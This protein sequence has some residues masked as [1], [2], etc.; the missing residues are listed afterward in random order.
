MVEGRESRQGGAGVPQNRSKYSVGRQL[1]RQFIR[2]ILEQMGLFIVVSMVVLYL[3]YDW[4]QK[5]VWTSITPF[6]LLIHYVHQHLVPCVIIWFLLGFVLLLGYRLLRMIWCMD[7]VLGSVNDLYMDNDHM[8]AMP[9]ELQSVEGQLQRIKFDAR[10]SREQAREAEQRKNDLIVYMAHDL[11]TPLTSVI[12][13]LSLL[14]EEKEISPE[15]RNKYQQIALRKAERLEELINEFFE[16]TRFNLSKMTLELSEINMTTM[17]EQIR[18]EFQ[19]LFSEKKLTCSLN[20]ERNLMVTCDVDKM[21]RVFDN[22]LKN[23]VNYSYENTE[24][25]IQAKRREDGKVAFLFRNQGKTISPEKLDR[26]FEQFFRLESSRNSKT[27]GAGLGLAIARDIVRL[28]GGELTCK[29]RE[30]T[31]SFFM[32]LP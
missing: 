2:K 19:P 32:V 16:I 12:G 24:I 5:R 1:T 18:W 23:A 15:I 6:Y 4:C 25:F 30:E 11:K 21:E 29:S 14:N 31:I 26:I 8:A 27:G 10:Q 20:L 9:A 3:G 7:A 17:L 28:H 13:Y 22:L